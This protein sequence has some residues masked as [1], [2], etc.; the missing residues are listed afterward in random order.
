MVLATLVVGLAG[1]C[2]GPGGDARSDGAGAGHAGADGIRSDAATPDGA[3]ANG[4]GSYS[5]GSGSTGSGALGNDAAAG[6]RTPTPPA[7][8]GTD[9]GNDRGPAGTGSHGLAGTT[10]TG[11]ATPDA[12]RVRRNGTRLTS[13]DITVVVLA[14]DGTA[15][16]PE[17]QPD[18]SVQAVVHGSTYLATPPGTVA[19]VLS[20][21]SA[22]LRDADGRFVAGLAP[23]SPGRL[24]GTG[25]HLLALTTDGDV[26]LRLA[27]VAIAGTAWGNREGGRSLAVTP[28]P[29]A[30]TGGL[31]AQEGLWEQLVAREPEADSPSMHDQL[32][33]H[34]LGAPDK[35]QWNLEPWRP[36]VD[37][38]TMLTSR[39]NPS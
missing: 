24:D 31:A 11:D 38:L 8:R 32:L 30:R 27:T 16:V 20:D 28:T 34:V 1:G 29:W 35:E 4:S 10:G 9:P 25:S 12:D 3:E 5:A 15:P 37:A 36:Q 21:T 33:C 39:C 22:V 18:G 6:T 17:P 26:T 2:T 19:T 7:G 14:A 13:G 23:V